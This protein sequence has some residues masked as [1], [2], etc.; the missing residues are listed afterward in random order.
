[1][2]SFAPKIKRLEKAIGYEFKDK[3]LPERALTHR[4]WAHEK[5]AG[6]SETEVRRLHNEALEFLGDSVLGLI[7]AENLSHKFP[8]SKE[9][10]LTLMKHRLVSEATLAKVAEK[11]SLGDFLRVGR[12]EE[13]SGGRRKRAM[14]ADALEAIIAA[15]FSDSDYLSASDFVKRIF[16]EELELVTPA[17]S[18]DYKTLLQEKLQARERVMP[19]Y[20]LVETQGPPH[21]RTF[22]VEVCWKDFAV[23]GNGS[24]IKTAEM[25]AARIALEKISET[26]NEKVSVA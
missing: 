25:M 17:N 14:L 15:V 1:M 16:G 21:H 7:I 5:T 8:N 11:Y 23:K 18:L 26:E 24:S 4:S 6:K 9:G 10:E 22:H 3:S 2:A 13:K 12:G 20:K 19:T